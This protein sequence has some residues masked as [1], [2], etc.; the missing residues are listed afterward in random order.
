VEIFA[1]R[2]GGCWERHKM[3]HVQ[4][5]HP[6]Q[7]I[8]SALSRAGLECCAAF[9]QHPGAVLEDDPDEES[10]IKL[11]YLARRCAS[12]DTGR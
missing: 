12:D 4:R 5:H 6:R 9:G 2:P 11:V 8:F 1:E 7:A 3:R 10:H